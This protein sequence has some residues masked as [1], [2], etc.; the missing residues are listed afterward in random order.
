MKLA[1]N[2]PG[3]TFF[4]PSLREPK[5]HTWPKVPVRGDSSTGLAW[6]SGTLMQLTLNSLKLLFMITNS[7]ILKHCS[8]SVIVLYVQ[9]EEEH[10]KFNQEY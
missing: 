4:Q 7:F 10:L 8:I 9:I 5:L 3:A 1:K 6:W 2:F